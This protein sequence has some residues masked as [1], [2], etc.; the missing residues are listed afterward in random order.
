MENGGPGGR[1]AG[2]EEP[3]IPV[4]VTTAVLD[5]MPA[6]LDGSSTLEAEEA[7]E[8]VSEATGVVAEILVEEGDRVRKG[9]TL[10]RLA[11]EEIELA[12]RKAHAEMEKLRADYARSEALAREELIAEEDYQTVRFDLQRA[13]IDWRQRKLE[14]ER[15]WI[16]API[17]GTITERLINLGALVREN[18]AVFRIVDFNSLVA[19]VFVP[20]KYLP[21]LRV[22]QQ[23]RIRTRG[24]GTKIVGGRILRIS[25]IVDAESGTVKL[26]VAID[27]KSGLRPGMFANVQIVLDTHE[28]VVVIPK[29]ALVFDDEM[30]HAFVVE[31][32]TA[33]KRRLELGYQDSER[34][35]IVSGLQPGESIVLVGQSALK[36][37]S[38]V[39][40]QEGEGSS[41]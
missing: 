31:E 9:Q 3:K 40:V 11:Y 10:A 36:D 22:S 30:P 37:G 28:N 20:E 2:I 24:S 7:V 23:A 38:P 18:S 39:E 4:V 27:Q 29:K 8:I 15:T 13:E 1:E 41:S 5:D 32:G 35:E 25:P 12:E 16:Q 34:A 33:S 21:N 19:P 17:S 14:L 26:T 6:F